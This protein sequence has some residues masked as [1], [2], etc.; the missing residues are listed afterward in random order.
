MWLLTTDRAE[1]VWYDSPP[2]KYAILSHVWL[3]GTP[4]REQSFQDVRSIHERSQQAGEDHLSSFL[5]EKI[6][7]CCELAAAHGFKLVWIDTCCINKESSAELSEALN[8][9]FAWYAGSKVCYAYLDDVPDSEPPRAANSLFRKSQ[10]FRRGWTLQELIAPRDV[11][12][13]SKSWVP[14]ASK[15]TIPALLREIT[16]IDEAVLLGT[17]PLENVSVARRLSW[18]SQRETTRIEDE[19]YC[20]MGIFNVHLPVIYGQGMEA[21]IRLQEE[22][23]RRIPDATML[24]WGPCGDLVNTMIGYRS[25]FPTQQGARYIDSSCLLASRPSAFSG[26]AANLIRVSNRDFAI[27]FGLHRQTWPQFA[28]TSHGIQARCPVVTFANGCRLL[29]LPCCRRVGNAPLLVALL[30]REQSDT[31]SRPLCVG[32]RII[33]EE[34]I[35]DGNSIPVG[36]AWD[37][38]FPDVSAHR[39]MRVRYVGR[40]T[41]VRCVLIPPGFDFANCL[42]RPLRE[43]ERAPRPKWK[44]CYIA[45]L[46]QH[47]K[48]VE[49]PQIS[50]APSEML[51]NSRH[52]DLS[53]VRSYKLYFPDWALTLVERQGFSVPLHFRNNPV[54]LGPGERRMVSFV[55]EQR[56]EKIHMVLR[57]DVQ[58]PESSNASLPTS[59]G[60]LWCTVLLPGD[61]VNPLLVLMSSIYCDEGISTNSPTVY[62]DSST[63]MASKRTST[64]TASTGYGPT[65]SGE[66]GFVERWERS[67]QK[68]CKE[69]ADAQWQFKLAFTRMC[70]DSDVADSLE[71]G[72]EVCHIYL[73]DIDITQSPQGQ[74]DDW[75]FSDTES[76]AGESGLA[77]ESPVARPL[78]RNW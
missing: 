58:S 24:A 14:I 22:I 40:F 61:E 74:E 53:Y 48:T 60:S 30:L 63:A 37:P 43:N 66:D 34:Q 15:R 42:Q 36:G 71:T 65:Y 18:A 1:L 5:S 41:P 55:N 54:E 39:T 29:L 50:P 49:S 7:R 35:A 19:A 68:G 33:S 9:M 51:A 76:H 13:L 27:A 10:W 59:S 17:M 45:Y 25:V 72:P 75:S 70:G 2:E 62:D 20:L 32:T 28:V 11:I 16:G 78:P 31:E 57:A 69:F 8:S 77:P 47:V 44:Q 23:L 64:I 6:K 3:K 38:F 73:V 46:R 21:F 12:F 56:G 52:G 67:G 26:D 4:A